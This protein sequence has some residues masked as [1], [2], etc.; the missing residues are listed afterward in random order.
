MVGKKGE[1]VGIGRKEGGDEEGVRGNE[2]EGGR[3]VRERWWAIR[4]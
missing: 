1:V 3:T 2:R 4:E